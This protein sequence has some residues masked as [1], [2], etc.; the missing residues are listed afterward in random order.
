MSAQPIPSNFSA[1]PYVLAGAF[2]EIATSSLGSADF[3]WVASLGVVAQTIA[4]IGISGLASGMD[5]DNRLKSAACQLL[6]NQAVAMA[7]A[8]SVKYR[9]LK[10]ADQ[11]EESTPLHGLKHAKKRV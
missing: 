6:T 3:P 5:N 8:K 9:L 4:G 1:L 2:L 11:L 7:Q 10:Y